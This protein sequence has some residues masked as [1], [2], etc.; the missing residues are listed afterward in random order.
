MI[1]HLR[2]PGTARLR[3]SSMLNSDLPAAHAA[4]IVGVARAQCDAGLARVQV[5]VFDLITNSRCRPDSHGALK[6]WL[7]GTQVQSL[8]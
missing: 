6:L 4:A 8:T 2:E 5:D 1:A 7:G 3:S